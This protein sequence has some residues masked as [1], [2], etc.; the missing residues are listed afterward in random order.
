VALAC[1]CATIVVTIDAQAPARRP[2]ER[3]DPIATVLDA[4][5][6]HAVVGLG[7]GTHGNEQGHAFRLALI[8]DPRFADTVNDIVV[9]SGSANDQAV[10]DRFVQGEDVPPNALRDLLEQSAGA[11]P[12]WERPIYVEFFQAVR[13][14]NRSRPADRRLRILL[15]D[16][17]IDWSAVKTPADY[18]PW[19]LQRDS[20]PAALIQREVLARSRKALVIY[21]DGHLQARSERPAD[22]SPAFSRRRA[23]ASS[24]SPRRSSIWRASNRR[25]RR[26]AHRPR[27]AAGHHHRRCAVRGVL[28]PRAADELLPG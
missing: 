4:F 15:G 2:A 3:L 27:D 11:A 14:I 9:E 20:H 10:A 7:E 21:G 25:L 1:A 8:R 17:P 22:R 13:D 19:G 26:G 24:R 5:R 18:R 16:P 12:V 6:T 28:R 23:S